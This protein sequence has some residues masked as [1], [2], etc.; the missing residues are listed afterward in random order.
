M[1][2]KSSLH[3]ISVLQI[4]ISVEFFEGEEDFLEVILMC[5]ELSTIPW[6]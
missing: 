4:C 6:W 3:L 5:N 2:I 1:L